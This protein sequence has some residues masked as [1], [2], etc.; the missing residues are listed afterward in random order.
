MALTGRALWKVSSF[1][2]RALADH[3]RCKRVFG[4]AKLSGFSDRGG[5][6]PVFAEAKM[7]VRAIPVAPQLKVSR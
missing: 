4:L 7:R 5:R 6:N 2:L 3:R 1:A